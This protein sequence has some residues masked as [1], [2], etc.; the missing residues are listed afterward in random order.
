MLIYQ[1]N[2]YILTNPS[3]QFFVIPHR[4]SEIHEEVDVDWSVFRVTEVNVGQ[5]YLVI[6]CQINATK[7]L[8]HLLCV[9]LFC[10]STGYVMPDLTWRYGERKL[11][12]GR[13]VEID[14]LWDCVLC[15]RVAFPFGTRLVIQRRFFETSS[16]SSLNNLF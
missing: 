12:R 9:S 6:L 4:V 2:L 16:V 5:L 3:N 7:K 15:H 11:R 13:V 1:Y 10:E 14:F 8:N